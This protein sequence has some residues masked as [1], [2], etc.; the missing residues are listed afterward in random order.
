M[1][2]RKFSNPELMAEAAAE[3][4]LARARA[5]VA[6][7]GLFSLVLAGGGTPLPLYRLLAAEPY[8]TEMPWQQSH[9][10]LGDERCLPPTHPESNFGRAAAT[11]L[12]PGQVPEANIHRMRGELPPVAGAAHYRRELAEFGRDFDLVLLGMGA[13]GHVASL[14]PGSPLLTEQQELVAA[15]SQPAGQ[16]PL[17]RLTLTLP[18]LNRAATVIVMVGGPAKAAIVDEIKRDR[19]AAARRYPAALIQAREESLWL[20]SA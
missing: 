5:A 8:L 12:A 10:F 19:Q 2:I 20:V 11:L 16:P 13:D 17:P 14:F 4:V 18:A 15:I 9:I 7:R 3:L 1:K 6:E